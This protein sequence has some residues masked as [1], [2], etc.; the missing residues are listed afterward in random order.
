MVVLHPAP[1]ALAIRAD[2]SAV[3]TRSITTWWRF[4]D[5]Q[6]TLPPGTIKGVEVELAEAVLGTTNTGD[7]DTGASSREWRLVLRLAD[8]TTREV[9]RTPGRASLDRKAEA[10]RGALAAL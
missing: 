9:Q 3:F 6:E 8:G 10:L 5:M 4:F 2:G 7:T 1:H